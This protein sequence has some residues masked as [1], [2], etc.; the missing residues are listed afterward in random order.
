MVDTVMYRVIRIRKAQLRSMARQPSGPRRPYTSASETPR[1]AQGIPIHGKRVAHRIRIHEP[2]VG[3]RSQTGRM[4][5]RMGG[6]LLVV[7][8]KIIRDAKALHRRRHP[9][10]AL[11]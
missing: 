3:G 8:C 2:L 10:E 11:C 4:R 6:I 9:E 5:L 1:E 7:V